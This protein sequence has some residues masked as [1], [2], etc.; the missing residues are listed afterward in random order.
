MSGIGDD[1]R[2]SMMGAFESASGSAEAKAKDE[3]IA[4]KGKV[5]IERGIAQ[6]KGLEVPASTTAAPESHVEG[7]PGE[8]SQEQPAKEAAPGS[9]PAPPPS[10]IQSRQ[11]EPEATRQEPSGQAQAQSQASTESVQKG[12]QETHTGASVS[13][14]LN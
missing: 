14:A 8:R 2:G 13:I 1:I 10:P 6:M 4:A 7:K 9:T 3:E 5:E 11:A 12:G